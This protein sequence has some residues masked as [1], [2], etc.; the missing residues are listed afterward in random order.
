MASNLASGIT[1][2]H[3]AC[4][5]AETEQG[6]TA[7]NNQGI[8]AQDAVNQLKI[9]RARLAVCCIDILLI[10]AGSND[11][12]GSDTFGNG[13]GGLVRYCLQKG[14]CD[15]NNGLQCEVAQS[16]S[17][18]QNLGCQGGQDVSGLPT[19]YKNLAMEI[20]CQQ[21]PPFTGASGVTQDP[22][23]GCTHPQKQ[24]PKLVL[25]TEY[26]DPSHDQSG[27]F[28]TNSSQCG[29]AFV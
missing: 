15:I 11:M 5:G 26:M 8:V 4:S 17:G 9:A 21:P 29:D 7:R 25:I 20:N 3:Y 14:Q 12:Y 27:N 6:D 24:I 2:I 28:P 19:Y 13:F 22:D 10:S 1:F 23:P 18:A 16:L